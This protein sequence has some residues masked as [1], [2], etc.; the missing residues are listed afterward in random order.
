MLDPTGLSPAGGA[1]Y[2]IAKAAMEELCH[3]LPALL[4]AA[5]AVTVHAPRLG[6]VDTDQTASL[7]SLPPAPALDAAVSHLRRLV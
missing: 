2:R 7:I 5:A 4:P 1:A 6:R 3:H